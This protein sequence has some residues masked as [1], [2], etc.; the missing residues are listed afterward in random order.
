MAKQ[1]G[2]IKLDGTMADIT[3]YRTKHGYMAKEK[4]RVPPGRI[5]ND[6]RFAGTRENMAEFG[7]VCNAAKVLRNAMG[8]TY[9]LRRK[10]P[11]E[12]TPV[13][14]ILPLMLRCARS[15]NT[16]VILRLSISHTR[17]YLR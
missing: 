13:Q 7:R 17:F 1:R 5:L 15:P 11:A 8:I 12:S 10:I 16:V 9:F 14:Q 2:I 6:P 4:L 3:F